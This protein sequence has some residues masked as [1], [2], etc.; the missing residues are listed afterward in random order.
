MIRAPGACRTACGAPGPTI[1]R[2]WPMHPPGGAAAKTP[3]SESM[4]GLGTPIHWQVFR[5]IIMGRCVPNFYRREWHIGRRRD[6]VTVTE[7]GLGG[8][9]PA[10][11]AEPDWS[12]RSYF[13]VS[14]GVI[15]CVSKK[16]IKPSLIQIRSL[17]HAPG[18]ETVLVK[19]SRE[20]RFWVWEAFAAIS[21]ARD[22]R[23]F[24]L[25][26]AFL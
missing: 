17:N 24:C 5:V 7:L 20:A 23:D 12:Q 22:F 21:K 4:H 16:R 6:P 10:A 18:P 8:R 13:N 11:L 19:F 15:T 9:R 26:F 3:E 25:R 2:R 1:R 14:K